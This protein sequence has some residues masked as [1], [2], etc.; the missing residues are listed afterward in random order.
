MYITVVYE[1]IMVS[2]NDTSI[3]GNAFSI[4]MMPLKNEMTR[5]AARN[6]WNIVATKII[7]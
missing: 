6:P 7:I 2:R 1:V 4:I 5:R 3:S